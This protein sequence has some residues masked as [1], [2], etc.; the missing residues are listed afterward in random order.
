MTGSDGSVYSFSHRAIGIAFG[1]WCT[2]I[3]AALKV[4]HITWLSSG[5][6]H[7]PV[8]FA[9]ALCRAGQSHC[10]ARLRSLH[11]A[12]A[13]PARPGHLLVAACL[14]ALPRCCSPAATSGPSCAPARP[15]FPGHQNATRT[16]A[17]LCFGRERAGP[18]L[19]VACRHGGSAPLTS[20]WLF[21]RWTTVC[22]PSPRVALALWTLSDAA[23]C[24]AVSLIRRLAA[25]PCWLA[26]GATPYGFPMAVQVSNCFGDH[27]RSEPCRAR[28]S[29][30]STVSLR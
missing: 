9:S 22:P 26:P 30:V 28:I 25:T 10:R 18:A 1:T 11:H 16:S 2:Q 17:L 7:H 21:V 29:P 14:C 20:S 24:V 5:R 3:L 19:H 8:W 6:G 23:R 13:R 12:R 15:R 4:V 27:R